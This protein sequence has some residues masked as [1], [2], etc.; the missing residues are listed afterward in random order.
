M[1][2][3]M[4]SRPEVGVVADQYGSPTYAAD[5]AAAILF[6][7]E[8]GNW[9]PGIY[10]YS[11]EGVITWF[12]FAQAIRQHI[13]SNCTVKAITTAEYPTPAKRP[14]YS[15]MD[16]TKIQNTFG[17]ELRPWQQSLERCM[18]KLAGPADH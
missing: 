10:H 9:V 11:N 15:V 16:K 6:I 5:L 17:L 4:N 1:L 3:L 2:R 13:G 18:Q 14:A 12:E 7:I 8:K